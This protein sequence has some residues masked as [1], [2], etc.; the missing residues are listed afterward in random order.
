MNYPNPFNASTSITFKIS[1]PM[2][3]TLK[4]YNNLGMEVATL[5]NSNLNA[6]DHSV[7]WDAT[8]S[9]GSKLESGIYYYRLI[10]GGNV[11][12]KKMLLLK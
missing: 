10:A 2:N 3:V 12:S 8:N 4:V 9:M 7:Q 5:V 11:I 1:T 6:G